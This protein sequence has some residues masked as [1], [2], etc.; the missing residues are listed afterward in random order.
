MA[1]H[2][3]EKNLELIISELSL[4]DLVNSVQK[5]FPASHPVRNEIDPE[6]KIK[7]DEFY[8]ISVLQ[9]LF[10]NAQIFFLHQ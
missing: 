4:F 6:L 7:V 10:E 8:F 3:S 5:D 2:I 1:S 9:N